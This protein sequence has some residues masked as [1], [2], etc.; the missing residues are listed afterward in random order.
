MKKIVTFL[1][2][3]AVAGSALAAGG[4]NLKLDQANIDLSDK[5]SLQRGA[6]NYINYCY[7]C[8]SLD[9]VRF[10]RIAKD[11]D[12]PEDVFVE[13]LIFDDVAFSDLMENAM[14]DA[15][16]KVWFGATPPDLTMVNR[17]KGSPDW[18]YTYLR[19][20]YKDDN[21]PLGV[22]NIVFKDVGM[23]HV[24]LELQGLCAE[25]PVTEQDVVYD[26]LSNNQV[27]ELGCNSYATKGLLNKAEFDEFAYDLTNFIAYVGEPWKLTSHKIGYWVLG[28]LFVLLIFAIAYYRELWKDVH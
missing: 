23:P 21:R 9:H 10:N 14:Q 5:E 26:T 15:E 20:F 7:S 11:L 16:A 19:G 1:L 17:I 3:L 24:L 8:H 28:Y 13:N 25:P 6:K 4:G 12:I 27:K 22:N 2:S 18:M